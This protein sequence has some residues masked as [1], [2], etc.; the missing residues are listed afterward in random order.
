MISLC[1]FFVGCST[2]SYVLVPLVPTEPTT[3]EPDQLIPQVAQGSEIRLTLKDGRKIKARFDGMVDDY[4][5]ISEARIEDSPKDSFSEIQQPEFQVTSK[6]YKIPLED[7]ASL[8]KFERGSKKE[9][10]TWVQ[11]VGSV[12]LLVYLMV[13]TM[14]DWGE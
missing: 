12:T 13:H 5:V 3:G 1:V 6:Q 7:V 10:I 11:I 9:V 14:D 8:E 4:L 2:T